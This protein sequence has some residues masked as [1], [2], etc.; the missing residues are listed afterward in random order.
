MTL[1]VLLDSELKA[2]AL[3]EKMGRSYVENRLNE[4]SDSATERYNNCRDIPGGWSVIDFMTPDE[5]S[6][7]HTLLLGLTL[8]TDPVREAR[9]RILNRRRNAP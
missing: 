3:F 1:F 2:V 6:E 8:C 4:I 9:E 7:R 5:L